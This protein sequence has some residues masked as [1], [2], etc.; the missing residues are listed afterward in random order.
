MARKI[1]VEEYMEINSYWIRVFEELLMIRKWLSCCQAN[2]NENSKL[3]VQQSLN[4]CRLNRESSLKVNKVCD[5]SNRWTLASEIRIIST[6]VVFACDE[7]YLAAAGCHSSSIFSLESEIKESTVSY[8]R[9]E[10]GHYTPWDKIG[11]DC[12]E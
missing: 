11:S 10:S 3:F 12:P 7:A 4:M 9:K 5:L 8:L 6:E 2:G 1:I